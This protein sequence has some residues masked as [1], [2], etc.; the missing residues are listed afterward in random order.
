MELLGQEKDILV[1]V[2]SFIDMVD[3]PG[4]FHYHSQQQLNQN[5]N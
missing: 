5:K 2:K 3:L 4:E 1:E